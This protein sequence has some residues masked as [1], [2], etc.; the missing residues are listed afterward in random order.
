MRIISRKPL[1]DFAKN[2]PHA[3]G[4]LDAWYAEVKK[5][6]WET[7]AD[8]KTKYKSADI[9]A[10]NRAIFNIGGNKYRLIVSIAY[11]VGIVYIK[12][13]GTHQEYDKITA[14]TIELK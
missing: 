5:A 3:K 4:P 8:I 1:N 10:G 14:A 2:H 12:F 11:Q 7:P 9:V 13:I 6:T